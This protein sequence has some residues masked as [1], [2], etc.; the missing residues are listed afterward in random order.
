MA[1]KNFDQIIKGGTIVSHDGRTEQDVAVRDGKIVEIGKFDV[2]RADEVI[3]AHGLHVLPGIIDTQVHFREPGAEPKED[4]ETG[5]RAAVLGGVTS[6][7]EMP[8]TRPTTSTAEAVSDKIERATHRMFCDFAFYVGATTENAD[9]LAELERMKGVC[10]VKVFMGSSTG[11]LLVAEDDAVEAVLRSGRRRVA[12]HS[13]DED[14]LK[15]CAHLA[16]AG[17]VHTH[18]VAR[19]VEAAVRCTH[20]SCVWPEKPIDAFMFSIFPRPTKCQFWH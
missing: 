13:E 6:V 5:S 7:F 19:D 1:I 8:N 14:R 2:N 15:E 18:A 10:G 12:V 4:L 16:E 20:G 11:T 9:K 17:N 3:D